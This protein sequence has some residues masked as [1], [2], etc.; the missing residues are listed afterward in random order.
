MRQYID[1]QHEGEKQLKK[2]TVDDRTN[3]QKSWWNNYMYYT[4]TCKCKN[5]TSSSR[6]NARSFVSKGN[7]SQRSDR[8]QRTEK[9]TDSG[10]L[11]AR[12][13][14]GKPELKVATHVMPMRHT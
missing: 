5:S 13:K 2:P 8:E 10:M 3:E 4:S 6:R 9:S 11:Q 12:V 7:L 1:S 14:I